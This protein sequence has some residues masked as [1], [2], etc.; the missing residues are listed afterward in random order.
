MDNTYYDE[1][2]H[3]TIYVVTRWT[4]RQNPS[5][6]TF[7]GF[8]TKLDTAIASI[9][10]SKDWFYKGKVPFKYIIIEKVDRG[11]DEPVMPVAYFEFDELTNEYK[12]VF[13]WPEELSDK[14]RFIGS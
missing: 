5:E 7:V 6:N 3:N 4:G 13:S 12:R 9:V 14:T 1:N 10:K 2:K 8:E 11:L